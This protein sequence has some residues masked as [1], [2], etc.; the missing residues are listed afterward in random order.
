MFTDPKELVLFLV[1]AIARF[2]LRL[3]LSF[4]L[5]LNASPFDNA[6]PD[7]EVTILTSVNV[8]SGELFVTTGCNARRA[9]A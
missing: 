8:V 4:P 5:R 6:R 2:P 3:S 9:T 1:I 7:V